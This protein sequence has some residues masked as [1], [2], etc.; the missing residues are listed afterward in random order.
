MLEVWAGRP[1]LGHTTLPSITKSNQ[2]YFTLLFASSV[3]YKFDQLSNLMINET[4]YICK[5]YFF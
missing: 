1:N 3:L 4:Q 2:G 5:R